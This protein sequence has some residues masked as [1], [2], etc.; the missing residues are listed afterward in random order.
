MQCDG[1]KWFAAIIND[2]DALPTRRSLYLSGFHLIASIIDA[3]ANCKSTL[4]S[5]ITFL[6]SIAF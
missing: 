5:F 4:P 1:G 2:N 6:T 3:R